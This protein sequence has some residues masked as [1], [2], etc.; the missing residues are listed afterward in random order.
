MN[1][2]VLLP[3]GS[4]H[5][6]IALDLRSHELAALREER[7]VMV[8]QWSEDSFRITVHGHAGRQT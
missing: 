7:V 6:K 4:E 5:I 8:S 1:A 3:V 2:V